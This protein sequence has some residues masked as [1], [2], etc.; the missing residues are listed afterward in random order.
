MAKATR[1]CFTKNNYTDLEVEILK[2]DL[3]QHFKYWCFGKEIGE[4]GTPHLQG[5]FE[6]ENGSKLRISAAHTRMDRV[7]VLGTHIE[8]AKGTAQQNITYC[9]KDG[10]FFEGGKRPKGQGNRSD[11]DAVSEM[12]GEGASITEIADA[13]P[14]Q[15]MRYHNG[16]EKLIRLKTKPR[17]SKT[18]V[19]WLWGPTGSGKSRYAWEQDPSSY[20]KVSTHKW[21]DGYTGQEN[22]I[23]DD[24]RPSKEMPFH[25]LLNLFDRYPLSVEVKGGMAEF[26]TKKIFVTSP[27]SPEQICSQLDWIGVEAKAQLMRRIDHIVEFPQLATMFN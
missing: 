17:F 15:F 14:S 4:S 18:E 16:I 3:T 5:Y 7:G 27:Y 6:F 19:W 1:F 24:Y 25:F 11:L 8:I 26:V 23:L 20:M 13:F 21:W 22:V 12:A 9:S 2:S 10:D